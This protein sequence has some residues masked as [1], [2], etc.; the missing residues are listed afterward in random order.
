MQVALE[1]RI[2]HGLQVKGGFAWSKSL[3]NAPDSIGM[4]MT[5]MGIASNPRYD[6]GL[7]PFSVGKSFSLNGIYALPLGTHKS[8]TGVLLNGWQLSWIYMQQTGLPF[9]LVDGPSQTFSTGTASAGSRPNINPAFTGPVILGG[10]AQYFNPQAFIPAPVGSFGN[11]GSAELTGP[12]LGNVDMSLM[13]L[14]KLTE[15]FGLQFRVDAFNVLN[16]PNWNLP[17]NSLFSSI[18]CPA[19]ATVCAPGTYTYNSQAG[20]ATATVTDAREMQFSLKLNF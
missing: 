14:F 12:G 7:A 6:R 11:A 10:P 2:S 1:T 9:R 15:R 13:K 16:H 20:A 18:N 17:N 4:A 3:T 8:A 5:P 19:T